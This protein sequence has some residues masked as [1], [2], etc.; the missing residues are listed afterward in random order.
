M[1]T[2]QQEDSIPQQRK[3]MRPRADGAGILIVAEFADEGISG[4]KMDRRDAFH[5]MLAYCQEAKRQGQPIEAVVCWDSKR[6]SRASS[7]ETNH[8]L[9]EFMA[10]GVCRLFTHSDGWIDFRKEEQRVLF[11]LRQDISNNRDLRDRARDIVRG[12]VAAA[13][14]GNWNGGAPPYGLDRIV[15]DAT[16]QVRERIPRG[17]KARVVHDG[18]SVKLAPSAD[19]VAVDTV[20]W[21]FDTFAHRET[22]FTWMA[23]DLTRRGVEGPGKAI[24]K[25][26]GAQWSAGEVR[27]ILTNAAYCGDARYGYTVRGVYYR[28][29]GDEIKEAEFGAARTVNPAALVKRDNHEAIIDR[30]LWAL[31]EE[32]LRTRTKRHS[33]IRA[34]GMALSGGLLLCGHC[35][36]RMV[37]VR[38]L[39]PTGKVYPYYTCGSNNTYPGSCFPFRIREDRV[40]QAIVEKLRQAYLSPARLAQLTRHV[41][42][43]TESR[44]ARDPAQANRLRKRIADLDR[45]IRQGGQN[46]VRATDNLDLIQ[47]AITALRTEKDALVKELGAL[48]GQDPASDGSAAA[49]VVARLQDLLAA[50]DKATPDRLRATLDAMVEEITLYFDDPPT[51]WIPRKSG[52]LRFQ[53]GTIKIRPVPAHLSQWNVR[54]FG[55]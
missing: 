16:G 27:R 39:G 28:F 1:S 19:T 12:K 30:R 5:E 4:G 14:A 48:D 38:S 36:G 47:Q 10:A 18:C 9:W 24:G 20:R 15:V 8:Y 31:V 35:G 55:A 33:R 3:V 2:D 11:N 53:K 21:I 51:K 32:K 34:T 54:S 49:D 22:S 44:Q 23:Q 26:Q 13:Q 29:V 17:E 6:F 41:A 7:I 40:L 42:G 45:D 52:K 37:G 25:C 46:L 43:C 50:L